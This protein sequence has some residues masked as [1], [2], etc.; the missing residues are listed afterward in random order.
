MR[1]ITQ[2]AVDAFY[3]KK[4]YKKNNTRIEIEDGNP[5]MF[6]HGHCIAKIKNGKL[7]I[8]HQNWETR[9]TRERLNGLNNVHIRINKGSFILNEKEP[10]LKEW[11]QIN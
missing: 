11:Y 4:Y 5:S 9:T 2:E 8:N 7:F 3:N 10:M 6:L 1:K